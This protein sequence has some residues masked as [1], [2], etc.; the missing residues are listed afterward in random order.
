[1]VLLTF[2]DHET[3]VNNS[4]LWEWKS[5]TNIVEYAWS[6]SFNKKKYEVEL[7]MKSIKNY[8]SWTLRK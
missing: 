5:H 3:E 8:E 7:K 2:T 6:S 1:M 4:N